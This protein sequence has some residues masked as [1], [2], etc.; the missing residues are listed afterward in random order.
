MEL[1]HDIDIDIDVSVQTY[2]TGR[3]ARPR[4]KWNTEQPFFPIPHGFG[5]EPRPWVAGSIQQGLCLLASLRTTHTLAYTHIVLGTEV[6]YMVS[7]FASDQ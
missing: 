4:S 5:P 6:Q 3:G 1:R 7:R 2:D